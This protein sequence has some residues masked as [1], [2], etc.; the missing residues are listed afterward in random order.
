MKKTKKRKLR[1]GHEGKKFI[2]VWFDERTYQRIQK[3]AGRADM[4]KAA[5]IRF[6]VEGS[7]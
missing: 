2:G 3:A 4:K 5:L 7:L 1:T 6:I